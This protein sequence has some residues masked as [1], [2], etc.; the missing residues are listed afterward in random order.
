MVSK[1]TAGARVRDAS[2]QVGGSVSAWRAACTDARLAR[3]GNAERSSRHRG[4]APPRRGRTGPPRIGTCRARGRTPP[5]APR[6]R[7]RRRRWMVCAR[8]RGTEA[9]QGRSGS[10]PASSSEARKQGRWPGSGTACASARRVM[11]RRWRASAAELDHLKVCGPEVPCA[12]VHGLGIRGGTRQM[13]CVGADDTRHAPMRPPGRTI[14]KVRCRQGISAPAPRQPATYNLRPIAPMKL[15]R[16]SSRG[17]ARRGTRLHLLR[18]Q[19]ARPRS[20]H[21]GQHVSAPAAP[22][23]AVPRQETIHRAGAAVLMRRAY[24][25]VARHGHPLARFQHMSNM[26]RGCSPV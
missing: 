1:Q 20:A 21:C 8:P 10:V 13:S 24:P 2:A 19:I 14:A 4:R 25:E 12:R 5:D 6:A 3:S 15:T 9:L 22:R 23:G 18:V 7:A 11:P 26:R 17:R 16:S